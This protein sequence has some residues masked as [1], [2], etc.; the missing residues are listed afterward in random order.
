MYS[1]Q[2]VNILIGIYDTIS[3]LYLENIFL[4]CSKLLLTTVWNVVMHFGQEGIK[5]GAI[6]HR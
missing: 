3:S 5:A 1:T 4:E 6:F 2:N